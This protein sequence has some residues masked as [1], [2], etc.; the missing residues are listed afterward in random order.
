[1]SEIN[2][3]KIDALVQ[4]CFLLNIRDKGQSDDGDGSHCVAKIDVVWTLDCR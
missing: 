1:M 2:A 4:E 3:N